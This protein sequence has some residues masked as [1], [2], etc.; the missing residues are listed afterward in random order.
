MKICLFGIS[1]IA[2]GKHNVKDPRLDQAHQLV[3][4]QKKTY[5]QVDVVDE[6]EMLTADAIL[7]TDTRR[8]SAAATMKVGKETLTI[9]GVCKGSGMIGPKLSGSPGKARG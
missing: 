4:A 6:K 7:T 8:K 3:E 2:L 5:A 1:G 9:A